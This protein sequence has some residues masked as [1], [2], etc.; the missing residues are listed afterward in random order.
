MQVGKVVL[1][2][3]GVPLLLQSRVGPIC[4][5]GGL[6]LWRKGECC[7]GWGSCS[8]SGFSCF[9]C[10]WYRLSVLPSFVFDSAFVTQVLLFFCW[11]RTEGVRHFR[12]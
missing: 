6:L 11:W 7:F 4:L 1:E 10:W 8:P 3:L 12:S 9:E 5:R 2:V